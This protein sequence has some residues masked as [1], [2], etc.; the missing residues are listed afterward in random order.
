[1]LSALYMQYFADLEPCRLCIVQRVF[2]IGTGLF[3]LL[4]FLHNP[5]N[6]GKKIY[7]VLALIMS[8]LGGFYAYTHVALQQAA[9]K[10]EATTSCGVPVEYAFEHFPLFEALEMFFDPS[11]SCSII[12]AEFLGLSIPGWTLVLFVGLSLLLLWQIVRKN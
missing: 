1:M 3:A 6:I 9:L 5:K 7:S 2:V 8:G 4:A 10:G 11:K 12:D